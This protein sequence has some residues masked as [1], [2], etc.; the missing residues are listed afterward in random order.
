ME[1]VRL[2]WD[3]IKERDKLPPVVRKYFI[4]FLLIA[5]WTAIVSFLTLFITS[6]IPLVTSQATPNVGNLVKQL[7]MR[8]S[9][10]DWNTL[11]R[12]NR[13]W[14][15]RVALKNAAILPSQEERGLGYDLSLDTNWLNYVIRYSQPIQGNVIT[16]QV[17]L[18]DTQDIE[19][20]W[21]G[22]QAKDSVEGFTLVRSA[23]QIPLGEWT[24]LVID[25]RGKY[26]LH[27][28]PLTNRALNFEVFFDVKGR[29]DRKTDQIRARLD[30]IAWYRDVGDVVGA[31]LEQRGQG[32]TLYDFEDER[33]DAWAADKGTI[34]NPPG[35][36]CRGNVSLKW[37]VDIQM[38]EKIFLHTSKRGSPPQGAWIVRIY[39]PDNGLGDIPLWANLYTYSKDGYQDSTPLYLEKGTCNTLVWDTH[40]IDW[41][42]A[43]DIV[44]G[45]QIKAERS[46]YKGQVFI[47][48]FQ[49]FEK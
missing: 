38:G 4:P 1:A 40:Q 48:D 49:M 33:I 2:I 5:I 12:F 15:D 36:A 41:G 10:D 46:A 6:K 25:L 11:L 26:D 31:Q 8:A 45:I 19:A 16:A 23:T 20:N 28:I 30:N 44:A 13:V 24:Q 7:D 47:D 21:V 35:T 39:L 18:P 27:G 37:D 32:H 29:S 42:T 9:L 22:I 14:G 34:S 3:I 43:D 17:Y